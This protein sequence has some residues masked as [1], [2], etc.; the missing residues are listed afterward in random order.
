MIEPNR[1]SVL[2]NETLR[3]RRLVVLANREPYIHERS[4]GEIEV[5][6]PASGL[7]TGIE[8]LLAAT[9]GVW[10]AHGGGSA[11]RDVVDEHARVA[12]PP[13]DPA[14][15]LRR[16]WLDEKEVA[17]YYLGFSNEALWPLCHLAY[18]KPRFRLSDYREY[19][20]VNRKFVA[21]ALE[22]LDESSLV[23][24]QD[25]HFALAPRMMREGGVAAAIHLFWHI[26]WPPAE[27]FRI[28]PWREEIL[29][30][31]LGADIA[32]F[33]SLRYCR[34]FLASCAEI[35]DCAVD[36]E[37]M[38]VTFDGRLT[39]VRRYP[40]S[41]EWPVEA[42]SR[43]EGR[44]VRSRLAIPENAHV[45]VGVDR[46]DY[47][48]GLIERMDGIERYLERNPEVEGKFFFI[49]LASPS[50]TGIESYR[51]L[52]TA[53]ETRVE[54]INAR[55]GA[56]EWTPVILERR[57]LPLEE[58]RA[59]YAAADSCLVT[60]LHDGMNLVAKE[61]VG[62]CLDDRGVLI[63]S[64]FTGAAEELQEALFVNP[65]DADG[66]ASALENAVAMPEEERV[67]RMSALRQRVAENTIDDWAASIIEDT[68][69]ALA[70]R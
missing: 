31:I 65:Y 21:A 38:Q 57:V 40:I 36:Y 50:R 30:G 64:E 11:D 55:F 68:L 67:Q 35:L 66:I 12:V 3:D 46:I 33:H 52:N 32:G 15:T 20:A 53:L 42:A 4:H 1:F 10:I 41:I 7:V 70:S 27:I 5:L 56:A 69:E 8:P 19:E 49:E 14:Y 63:L 61:Y 48:K 43:E 18:T 51:D 2:A 62:S 9:G 37:Q 59:H 34:N 45:T 28:C 60:P 22:E 47:T 17:G 16:I 13:D 23:L 39:R 29:R 58:L 26:P 44:R 25:Y 24:V 6:R 54:Q